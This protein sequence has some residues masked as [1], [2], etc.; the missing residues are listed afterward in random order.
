[1]NYNDYCTC[2]AAV[3]CPDSFLSHCGCLACYKIIKL[4]VLPRAKGLEIINRSKLACPADQ[5][6]Y[7]KTG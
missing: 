2:T 3:S 1:M 6:T 5:L 7:Y 4:S